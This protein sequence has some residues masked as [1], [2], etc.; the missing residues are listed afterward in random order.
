MCGIAG[1]VNR[2]GS[3][4]DLPLL[5][6]ML[7]SIQH[8]GPD[9]S[10][11][12][13]DAHAGLG[14]V[15]L[16]IIDIGGGHQPMANEDESLWITF[17]GEIFN[18][19]ELMADL[20]RRG[21]RFQSRCDTEVIIHAYEE[22]G[23]DCV[24][25]FNGQWSFAIW[26]NRRKK[27]FASR[28]R[29]GVRPFFYSESGGNFLFASE[30]KALLQHPCVRR[31]IDL[32]GLDQIFTTWGTVPPRTIFK[33]VHEL[34]PGHSLTWEA[35]ETRVSRFWRPEYSPETYP[36]TQQQYEEQLLDLLIDATRL[37]LRSDVPVG[38]YLSGGLD[39]SLTTALIKR[40]TDSQLTTFSVTFDDPQFD[41][42]RF[43]L[44]VI[45]H[46]NTKH[47]SIRCTHADIGAVFP[48]VIRH[49]EKPILRT[50]PAPLFLLSRLVRDQGYK[51]VITGE[52]ADEM[53]GGYDIFKEAKIRRFWA[54]QPGS[55]IRPQLLKRLY[56][57]MQ[58][59]QSQSPAYLQAFFHVRP[60][61]VANPFFSHLPR[62]DLT[63]KLKMF[64]SDDVRAEL[65]GYDVYHDL[66]KQLPKEFPLWDPFCQ[67]QFLETAFLLPGYILSSQGDRMAMGNSVEGRFPFL[68]FRL[69]E[70]AAKLPP[71]LK[72]RGTSEKDILKRVAGEFLPPTI[73]SRPKQPYRAPDAASFFG[74][75]DAPVQLDYVEETLSRDRIADTGIF[76]PDAVERLV[77][78]ARRGQATGVKDNMA[79]VGILSTQ[80]VIDQ[81]I[82]TSERGFDRERHCTADSAVCQ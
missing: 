15:R 58:S 52:G 8:R 2:E 22:F 64:Y 61:D 63:A 78:K 55:K 6:D 34:P 7:L 39:S 70:F 65:A 25:H 18:Y 36:R 17:N 28:D 27:L 73:T 76:H 1:I 26:D 21:H 30:I 54:Q 35:G 40:F 50:A 20:K 4:I 47:E 46:L 51:V 71:R 48:E 14:H 57:Y 32:I 74:T 24:R 5:N 43:Q 66:Q 41:E 60:E 80:L 31:E 44:D 45:R 9:G 82:H 37:R 10:G 33:D 69:A 11:I 59:L 19:V 16:S 42:S 77:N 53:L 56:P 67:S 79:L 29:L 38:A 75:P 3:G 13:R 12:Y 23:E 68:D 62:W 49:T 72:M 81:F